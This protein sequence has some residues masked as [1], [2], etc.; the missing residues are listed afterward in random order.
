MTDEERAALH[1]LCFDGVPRPWNAAEF[2]EFRL[3]ARVVDCETAHG[4]ILAR[5]VA[6]EAEILT[7]AVH[8]DARRQG[9][10]RALLAAIE[11]KTAAG[12][13]FLEVR[14]DNIAARALYESA[15]YS[16]AG[17]RKN[18]YQANGRRSSSAIVLK[19]RL[20]SGHRT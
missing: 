19:K 15:G 16:S 2:A 4:F 11:S 6:E 5:V 12:E 7:L 1:A 13:F 10:G 14:D 9:E 20:T 17:H 3:D 18:Y 8:P